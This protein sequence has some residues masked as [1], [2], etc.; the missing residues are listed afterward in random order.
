MAGCEKCGNEL[1]ENGVCISCEPQEEVAVNKPRS[2]FSQIKDNV[3][4]MLETPKALMILTAAMIVSV[5]ACL[6]FSAQR[7]LLSDTTVEASTILFFGLW[8]AL[9]VIVGLFLTLSI[10]YNIKRKKTEK[11]NKK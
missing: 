8:I 1:D 9:A 4:M 5:L 10:V 3:I 7:D 6:F 11:N 2:A